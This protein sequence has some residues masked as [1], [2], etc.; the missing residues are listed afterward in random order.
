MAN[1]LRKEGE[2]QCSHT[3]NPGSWP[4]VARCI[5]AAGHPEQHMD[6]A[7]RYWT[8][9]GQTDYEVWFKLLW[10]DCVAFSGGLTPEK[11]DKLFETMLA[12]SD[13]QPMLAH[14]NGFNTFEEPVPP[15]H[16]FSMT[17]VAKGERLAPSVRR[18]MEKDL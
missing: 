1:D 11:M 17:I 9:T 12:I 3:H 7:G 16:E 18:Q 4:Y 5:W 15:G 14:D 2:P 6:A 10:N 8:T 13:G